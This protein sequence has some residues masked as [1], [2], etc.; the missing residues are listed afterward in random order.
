MAVALVCCATAVAGQTPRF[1]VASIKVNN[2]GG[3]QKKPA[4]DFV[5]SEGAVL[6]LPRGVQVNARGA[7]ARTLVRYAYGDIG[8]NGQIV[9][10]SRRSA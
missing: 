6:E 3:G 10:H 7:T 2:S 1:T 9:R 8:S 4:P 5:Q